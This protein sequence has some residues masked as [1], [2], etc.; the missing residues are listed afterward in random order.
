MVVVPNCRLLLKFQGAFMLDCQVPINHCHHSF[1]LSPLT[2]VLCKFSFLP[3]TFCFP[4]L[5]IPS[6]YSIAFGI[7]YLPYLPLI[8]SDRPLSLR[9]APLAALIFFLPTSSR[10]D[11]VYSLDFLRSSIFAREGWGTLKVYVSSMSEE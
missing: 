7:F 3:L 8:L 11:Q 4:S 9:S 6:L 5:C 1:C 2:Y 10:S